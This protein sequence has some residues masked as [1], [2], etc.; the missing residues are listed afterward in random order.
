MTDT[1]TNEP[2]TMLATLEVQ[3]GYTARIARR[4]G[5]QTPA[6]LL[7]S[8]LAFPFWLLGALVAFLWMVISW[9]YAAVLVGFEDVQTKRAPKL[10]PV[11][12]GETS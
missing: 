5:E 6:G 12:D 1:T 11:I 9:S 8:L 2:V 4:A 3:D 10:L 7:V